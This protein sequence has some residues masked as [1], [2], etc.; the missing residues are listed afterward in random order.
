MMQLHLFVANTKACKV[1]KII[2]FHRLSFCT[3]PACISNTD[4]SPP[5]IHCS[6]LTE[7]VPGHLQ[8]NHV[9]YRSEPGVLVNSRE[10]V[11]C[12]ANSQ[13]MVAVALKIK[14][15][16]SKKDLISDEIV[17]VCLGRKMTLC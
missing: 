1:N 8:A 15:D 17:K 9:I 4:S 14:L 3:F 5:R 10:P 6:E 2:W 12:G 16:T 13:D 7:P 11:G